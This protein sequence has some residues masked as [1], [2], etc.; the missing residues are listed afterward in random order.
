MRFVENVWNPPVNYQLPTKT[1]NWKTRKFRSTW[2]TEFSWLAYSMLFGGWFCVP[3]VLFGDKIG[4][5]NARLKNLYRQPLTYWTSASTNFKEHQ[6]K[7]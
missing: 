3:C 7:S 4:H 1:E 6:S 5:S 2:L